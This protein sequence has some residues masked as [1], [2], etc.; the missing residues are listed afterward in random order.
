M[1]SRLLLLQKLRTLYIGQGSSEK[2]NI[3]HHHLLCPPSIH[4]IEKQLET[5]QISSTGEWIS[6]VF[7]IQTIEHCST[8]GFHVIVGAD[9]FQI[10]R[11]CQRMETQQGF[12]FVVLKQNFFFRKYV[13]ALKALMLNG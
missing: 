5:I 7:K 11:A 2:K 3:H 1:K 6:T 10:H 8:F 12:Y 9:K 4:T 13:F